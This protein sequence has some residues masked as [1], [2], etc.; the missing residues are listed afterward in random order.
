MLSLDIVGI[1]VSKARRAKALTQT[2]LAK[3]AGVSRAT[4]ESLENGRLA[5]LG[6]NKLSR[7]LR[8]L[9]LELK[10]GPYNFQ[11]PTLEDLVLENEREDAMACPEFKEVASRMLTE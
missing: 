9:S 5:E 8:A 10:I 6:F 3:R 4:L 7:I 11:R 2:E 1:E